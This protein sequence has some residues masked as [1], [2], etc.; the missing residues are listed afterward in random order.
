MPSGA[1]DVIK[2]VAEVLQA[3]DRNFKFTSIQMV[4]NARAQ[5]HVDKGNV[6]PSL[7]L[8]LGRLEVVDFV[9]TTQRQIAFE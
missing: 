4:V 1:N 8:S 2:L 7:A 6:G 5:V 3:K 9:Y